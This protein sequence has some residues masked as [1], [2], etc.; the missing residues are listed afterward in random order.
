MTHQTHHRTPCTP[1]AR[2]LAALILLVTTLPAAAQES[3]LQPLGEQTPA[4]AFFQ[5]GKLHFRSDDGRFHLWTDNRIYLDAACYLPTHSVDDIKAK[6][7]KDLDADDGHFRFSNGAAVRRARLGIKAT[8]DERWFAE[9]DIDLAYNEVEIK[10]MFVGRRLG[11]HWQV[12][13]GHFKAPMSMERLTSSKY[14]TAL[15]RPMAVEAFSDGRRLGIAATGWGRGWWGSAGVFGRSADII[16]KERNR[17]NDGWGLHGRFALAPVNTDGLTLHLGVAGALRWPDFTGTE[18]R[19]VELRTFPESRI[20]RRRFVR[21][22]VK[23]VRRYATLGLEGGVRTRRLLA[24]GEYLYTRLSR[25]ERVGGVRHALPRADFDG[26]YATASYMLRGEQRRY[27]NADAEFGPMGLRRHGGNVELAARVSAID[28]NDFH[29][30]THPVTGGKAMA[31]TAALNWYPT[32]NLAFSLNYSFVNNDHFA[33]DKG[34][35]TVAGQPLATAREAGI[36]FHVC[37]M[38]MMV[39]F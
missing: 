34:G 4:R 19:T 2:R 24:Y 38:R 39:S 5:D 6:P 10:D 30:L 33:D 11:D 7:N 27:S 37:Q 31:Y 1:F 29:D 23:G 14:L 32:R 15:E 25:T 17:G 22:E 8:L 18:D 20:D 16:Q 26:W 12:K 28:M 36:D 21:A 35:L 13:A 9:L 3:D